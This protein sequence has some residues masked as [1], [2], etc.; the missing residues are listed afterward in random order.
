ML[1]SQLGWGDI[2]LL[3][4]LPQNQNKQ[5][6]PSKDFHL[7]RIYGAIEPCILEGCATWV[8]RMMV[9]EHGAMIFPWS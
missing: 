4:P 3:A 2:E 7:P 1:S 8:K 6:T 9:K 5:C